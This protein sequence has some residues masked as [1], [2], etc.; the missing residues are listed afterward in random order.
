MLVTKSLNRLI[1]VG[2]FDDVALLANRIDNGTVGAVEGAENQNF[3]SFFVQSSPLSIKP[4]R[5]HCERWHSQRKP[6]PTPRIFHN[7]VRSTLDNTAAA[8][9]R[10]TLHLSA[11]P[12]HGLNVLLRQR[13]KYLSDRTVR[14]LAGALGRG[15]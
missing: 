5:V 11:L 6:A 13:L 9:K 12:Q 15:T 10:F 4:S 2:D 3:A 1:D 8:V 14:M 7:L